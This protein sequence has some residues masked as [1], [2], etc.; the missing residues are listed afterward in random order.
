[1]KLALFGYGGHAREVARQMRKKIT[2]FVDDEYVPAI[3]NVK[4]ISSFN[5]EEYLMM[6]AIGGSKER[7]D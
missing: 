7:Y 3:P 2:F 4:G 1:M 5:P 6:V